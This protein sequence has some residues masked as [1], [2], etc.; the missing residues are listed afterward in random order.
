MGMKSHDYHIL[1]QQILPL[2]IQHKMRK[3]P[4]K[5]IMRIC[6]VFKLICIKVYDPNHIP[7]LEN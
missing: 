5:T 1:F 7:R 2:C 6:K 3:T 4:L